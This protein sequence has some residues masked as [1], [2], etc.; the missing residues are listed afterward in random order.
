MSP[1]S[2]HKCT[3]RKAEEDGRQ[4]EEEKAC[5]HGLRE[6]GTPAAT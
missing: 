1:K 2:H 4:A 5:D 3:E 6:K